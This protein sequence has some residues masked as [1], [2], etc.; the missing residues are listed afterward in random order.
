[1]FEPSSPCNHDGDTKQIALILGPYAFYKLRNKNVEDIYAGFFHFQPYKVGDD[2]G[3][4]FSGLLPK[5]LNRNVIFCYRVTPMLM[6]DNLI[7]SIN[8]EKPEVKPELKDKD[9]ENKELKDEN[10]ERQ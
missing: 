10:Y 4:V 5:H 6:E 3:Y 8:Y 9:L 2:S 1:V 7:K